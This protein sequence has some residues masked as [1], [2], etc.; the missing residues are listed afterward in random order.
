MSVYVVLEYS[1][2][3][4]R[5]RQ[6][7]KVLRDICNRLNIPLLFRRVGSEGRLYR[8]RFIYHP[9]S[10]QHTFTEEF[11]RMVNEREVERVIRDMKRMGIDPSRLTPTPV[12][13]I[14]Y[15]TSRGKRE[16]TIRGFPLDR[17]NIRRAYTNLYQTLRIIAGGVR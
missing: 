14:V 16:I 6:A 8:D 3:C 4:P 11:A 17:E 13:R 1:P 5:C 15:G 10:V 9:T 2:N 7:E 12:I